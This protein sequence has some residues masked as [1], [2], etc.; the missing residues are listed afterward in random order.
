MALTKRTQK[1]VINKNSKE[2]SKAKILNFQ[3]H[4]T[5]LSGCGEGFQSALHYPQWC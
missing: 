3:A 1:T 2:I 4:L 5:E